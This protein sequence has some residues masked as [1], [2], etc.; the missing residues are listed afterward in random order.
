MNHFLISLKNKATLSITQDLPKAFKIANVPLQFQLEK[1]NGT[2]LK[3]R[4][5]KKPIL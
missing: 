4:T 2:A 5:A 1:C 3:P